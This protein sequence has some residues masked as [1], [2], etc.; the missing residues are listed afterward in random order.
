[1]QDSN[2]G[3]SQNLAKFD[4]MAIFAIA[5][6]ALLFNY[7]SFACFFFADD[8]LCLEYLYKIFHGQPQLLLERLI[9]PWQDRSFSLLYRPALDLFFSADYLLWGKNAFGYHLTNFLLFLTATILLYIATRQISGHLKA[10]YPQ[11]IA[12]LSALCFA[13]YPLHVEAIVWLV[14][15]SDLAAAVFIFAAIIFAIK[16]LSLGRACSIKATA[17]YA[18]ALLSKEAAAC[19]PA[20]IF[21]YAILLNETSNTFFK[22]LKSILPLVVCTAIYMVLRFFVLGTFFGGYTGSLGE[23]LSYHWWERIDF[24][25]YALLGLGTNL[26]IFSAQSKEVIFLKS[27][28]LLMALVMLLRIPFEPWDSKT[29]KLLAFY[30]ISSACAIFPA[31]QV[32]GISNALTNSRVYF[33]ASAFFIPLIVTAV[34]LIAEQKNRKA[35]MLSIISILPLALLPIA[36][37]LI[38]IKSYTPWLDAS[39]VLLQLQAQAHGELEKLASNKKLVILNYKANIKGAHVL[40]R[41]DELKGLLGAV[42]FSPDYSDRLMALDEFPDFFSTSN[43]RLQYILKHPDRYELAFFDKTAEKLSPVKD[44]SLLHYSEKS[45][46]QIEETEDPGPIHRAYWAKLAEPSGIN[47]TRQIELKFKWNE[48]AEKAAALVCLVNKNSKQPDL[49]EIPLAIW[50]EG[51]NALRTV[52]INPIDARLDLREN[53]ASF[54]YAR[55]PKGAELLEVKLIPA[56]YQANLQAD[57]STLDELNNGNYTFK[58][59]RDGALLLDVSN[60]PDARGMILERADADYL[61]AMSKISARDAQ[62]YKHVEKTIK[63]DSIKQ[64]YVLPKSELKEGYRYAFRLIA[65]DAKGSSTGFYSNTVCIDLR[66]Q[67]N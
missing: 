45:Q 3:P 27:I 58:S 52:H 55:I 8:F 13:S 61:F 1:M 11:A 37:G 43:Q 6:C 5:G 48:K 28:Y 67:K 4:L 59:N 10:P 42:F 20:I 49:W 14:G 2:L 54:L 62:S 64:N 21:C 15:R 36:F 40:Y 29:N 12:L 17:F 51:S 39:K 66:K 9:S 24:N 31:L 63:F 16:D 44:E 19:L 22:A 35:Q 57:L 53:S 50:P 38:S 34:L 56:K 32:L 47:D 23:L 60:V 33:M 65:S 25:L 46:A 30:F 41:Y 18:L 7:K 26:A